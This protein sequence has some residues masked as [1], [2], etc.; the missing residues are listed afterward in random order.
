MAYVFTS[1][2]QPTAILAR[3]NGM[4][5]K[6]DEHGRHGAFYIEDEGEWI[7]EMSYTRAGAGTIVVDHTEV[8]EKL[9]GQGVGEQLVR[10]AVEFARDNNLKIKPT[11]PYTRKVIDETPEFQDVLAGEAAA[12]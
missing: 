8:D 6:H 2:C 12:G 9:R 7:A 11:C 1:S 5:I 4:E 3:L 10:R